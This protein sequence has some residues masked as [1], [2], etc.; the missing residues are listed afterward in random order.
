MS[1]RKGPAEPAPGLQLPPGDIEVREMPLAAC[2]LTVRY[3]VQ[4]MDRRVERELSYAAP[5]IDV[6]TTGL[7]L[8]LLAQTDLTRGEEEASHRA[9]TDEELQ[10]LVDDDPA[11]GEE[12]SQA[13]EDTAGTG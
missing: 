2:M 3:E 13:E 10:G 11:E 5:E 4:Y 6:E 8:L 1:P 7:Q 9:V 12:E